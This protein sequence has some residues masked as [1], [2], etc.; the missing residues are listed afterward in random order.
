MPLHRPSR[1]TIAR[2]LFPL[3]ALGV[4]AHAIVL[5]AKIAS[6]IL[7]SAAII[8]GA[9][10]VMPTGIAFLAGVTTI[11]GWIVGPRWIVPAIEVNLAVFRMT[12][13]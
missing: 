7:I 5:V 8:R 6:P 4:L 3:V 2:R 9:D 12:H 13:L 11:L 1:A 10:G